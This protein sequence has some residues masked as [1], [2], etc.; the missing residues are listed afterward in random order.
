MRIAAASAVLVLSLASCRAD[1]PA[2][3][4][5]DTTA[6][7]PGEPRTDSAS[8][9]DPPGVAS[10]L[11]AKAS[12]DTAFAGDPGAFVVMDVATDVRL[13]TARADERR[14]AASTFKT[15]HTVRALDLGIVADTAARLDYDTAAYPRADWWPATWQPGMTIG[16]A[17]RASA[18]PVYRQIG[19]QIGRERAEAG[20]AA[21]AYGN[22]T[23]GP[24][25]VGA[26]ADTYWLDGSL[27]I[28][29]A[30]QVAFLARLWARV[31]GVGTLPASPEAARAVRSFM[32][33]DSAAA[34]EGGHAVL[35][36]K[37]GWQNNDGDQAAWLVGVVERGGRAYPY[38]FV[39]D[40]DPA[41]PTER[42]DRTVALLRAAG[43]WP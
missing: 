42:R 11:N 2:A 12:L 28:S 1:P 30:E 10:H 34:P 6:S 22:R 20:L 37:T 40:R 8:V 27:R 13:A 14:S 25:S 19:A 35:F 41:T 23:V 32:R 17:F 9:F 26:D 29:P 38:A 36:G 39:L 3:S 31:H 18:V 16:Q 33:L 4:T 5:V 43:V 7:Q 21:F 15:P 24:D